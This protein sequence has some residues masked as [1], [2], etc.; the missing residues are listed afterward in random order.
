[1]NIEDVRAF[2]A[3]VDSGSVGKAAL[4]LNLTQPAISRRVQRL[5]ES[6]GVTLLD[7]ISKPARPTRA[8]EVAYQRCLAVLRATDALTRETGAALTAMPL[9]VGLSLAISECVFAPAIDALNQ[10]APGISLHLIADR[11]TPLRKAVTEGSLEAAVVATQTGRLP[12]GLRVQPLGEERVAVVA[13][14]EAGFPAVAAL[15]NLAGH[16]WVINPDGCGFRAQLERALAE[17]GAPLNVIAETWG[18]ALQLAMIAR[19]A[20]LGLVPERLVKA[21]PY[22]ARL[23]IVDVRGFRPRLSLS[24]VR[25]EVPPPCNAALDA[26]A[27]A[28]KTT[29]SGTQA[30]L[31]RM[32]SD[33]I[34]H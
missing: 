6:L 10:A 2:V 11:S 3:V 34:R 20:G 33:G 25:G 19:G 5:E 24:M 17:R 32:A 16:P 4:R 30:R 31:R 12:E 14:K 13:S 27:A 22:R 1:M 18:N 21:S 8:G 7:R 23:Q 15:D 9:R 28:V 29:L 26:M